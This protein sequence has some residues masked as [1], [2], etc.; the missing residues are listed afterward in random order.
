MITRVFWLSSVVIAASFAQGAQPPQSGNASSTP[1]E[2]LAAPKNQASHTSPTLVAQTAA[3]MPPS[4]PPSQ[5]APPAANPIAA[6]GSQTAQVATATSSTVTSYRCA[7]PVTD[8]SVVGNSG[9]VVASWG[10]INGGYVCQL[11]ATAPNGYTAEACRA[12]YA[13]LLTSRMTGLWS[14]SRK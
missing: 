11:G 2:A 4:A 6:S 5:P 12:I 3:P 1:Q 14:R 10:G 9:S 8:V 7:G 13:A